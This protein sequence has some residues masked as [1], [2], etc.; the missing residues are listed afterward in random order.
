MHVFL[1]SKLKNTGKF[2]QYDDVIQEQLKDGVIEP[3]PASPEGREFY[4]PH[5]GVFRDTAQS[6]KLRVVYDASARPSKDSLSLN[7]CLEV[8]PPLQNKLWSVLVRGRFHPV[9]LSG[10]LRKAFL[11]VR[12]RK[13]HRDVVRF[14]WLKDIKSDEV[15]TFRFTRALFGLT[16][17]P[18]LLGGVIQQHL[19]IWHQQSPAAVDDISKSLYVDDLVSGATTIE[20]AATL[21]SGATEIFQDVTFELH[22]WQSNAKE[23]DTPSSPKPDDE[24]YAKQQLGAP[25]EEKSKLLGLDWNKEDDTISITFPA[26]KA[27]MTKRGILSKVA[28]VHDP[29]GLVSPCTLA[30]KQLYREA[31]DNKLGWDAPLNEPL[32]RRVER[33]ENGLATS[34]EFPRSLVGNREDIEEINLHAFGD[35]SSKGVAAAVYAVVKQPS[36]TAQGLVAAKSRLQKQG[37]TIPRIE[38]VSGHMAA[39]LA[40]NVKKALDGFPVTGVTGWLDSTVALCWVKGKG[41]Y[42]QFVQNRV[43]KIREKA[44]I[45]WR[46]VPPHQNPADIGSRAGMGSND[47]QLWQ[48]GPDWLGDEESWPT[49][50]VIT[51]SDESRAE[52]KLTREVFSF[53]VAENDSFDKLLEKFDLWKVL[54]VGAWVARFVANLQG[55]ERKTT[56]D[57]LTT[58]EIQRQ[59]TFWVKRA[60]A[61]NEA[62]STFQEDQLQLNLQ[63]NEGGVYEWRGRL[64]GLYPTHLPDQDPFTEKLVM[65]AHVRTLHGGVGLTMTKLRETYWIP[66][67]RRLVRKVTKKC[68]GCKRFQAVALASPP[69]GKFP[70]D[71]TVGSS[72]FEVIGVD[73]A[74]PIPYRSAKNRERKSYILLYTCSLSR[75]IHLELL[76][77]LTTTEFIHSFKMFIARRGRP[78]K[79]YSDNGKTFVGAATWLRK[80]MKE[81]QLHNWLAEQRII[82]QFN[83]SRAPWWGGQFERMVGLVKQAL[84][85]TIGKACLYWK[86]LQEVILDIEMVL[87]NRPLSY[88]EEDVQMPILTPNSLM[89]GQPGVVPEE[90]IADIDDTN[91]RKR[92]RHVEKCKNALWARWSSEYLRGLRERH[93]LKHKTKE[94]VLKQGDVVVIR[95]DDR[96]RNKWK[97]GVVDEMIKGKDD[98]V[99]A[100]RLRAGKSF[101]ERPIQH[102]Y[103]LEL[104]CDLKAKNQLDVQAKE[105]KPKR[106]AA[107]AARENIRIIAAEEQS[108]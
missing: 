35:A 23:L 26:E 29:L 12:I 62:S 10:D 71:R 81:E 90:E 34:V 73:Y 4:I 86:E 51:E 48:N 41:Q 19:E 91:L 30:G 74:G 53:A 47:K 2:K 7:D 87:N 79:V 64:Q 14:H 106:M 89:F 40:D 98:V 59:T 63:R 18:F 36:G 39:N 60:Q 97:L 20:K 45:E 9:C 28:R 75:A 100:V 102:L 56:T 16:S 88:V 68:N 107:E 108:D 52:T 77:D 43:R 66:R 44:F 65:E 85:K 11:Q 67:L 5:K 15:Q 8:G 69:P 82:W 80:L 17:S 31:C 61:R 33:W 72:A 105:F 37:L 84:Y 32:A 6:T 42:K 25:A 58:K 27:E 46:H 104:S 57:P 92:A 94:H 13:S 99:R 24:T 54:R 103:P 55:R 22:K 78:K 76:P 70:S 50:P 49:I 83:L 38:L 96:N 21:K 93:N 1:V 95:G 3:I 101:L